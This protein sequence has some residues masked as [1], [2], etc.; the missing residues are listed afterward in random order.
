MSY[1]L[2]V[3]LVRG[4]RRE[5]WGAKM[6]KCSSTTTSSQATAQ[7]HPL[8]ALR[9]PSL[10]FLFPRFHLVSLGL[11]VLDSPV[12]L[13]T[14]ITRPLSPSLRQ[15]LSTRASSRFRLREQ[16]LT[17]ILAPGLASDLLIYSFFCTPRVLN[18]A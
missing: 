9:L 17:L 2:I 3:Q 1:R 4:W 8:V 5:I 14:S 13:P 18:P 11:R 6:N 15:L 10:N 12:S 7:I 16:E